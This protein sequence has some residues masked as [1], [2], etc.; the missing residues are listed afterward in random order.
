M[1]AE[2]WRMLVCG[3]FGAACAAERKTVEVDRPEIEPC[4]IFT[5]YVTLNGSI[6]FSD[7]NFLFIK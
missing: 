6:N 2:G 5:Y 3:T 4:S 1:R 7:A